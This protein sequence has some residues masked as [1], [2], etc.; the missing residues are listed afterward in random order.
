MSAIRT[1]FQTNCP[2]VQRSRQLRCDRLAPPR[3]PC[4]E[5]VSPTHPDEKVKCIINELTKASEG[6]DVTFRR[7]A[8]LSRKN[9]PRTISRDAR[10]DERRTKFARTRAARARAVDALSILTF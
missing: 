10:R 3:S 1:L 4:A 7:Y 5:R 8:A 6:A 9:G 2:Q